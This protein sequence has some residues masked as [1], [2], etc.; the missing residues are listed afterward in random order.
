MPPR[1]LVASKD[2]VVLDGLNETADAVSLRWGNYDLTT[3]N[4]DYNVPQ[5]KIT[6]YIEF[7]KTADF[8]DVTSIQVSGNEKTFTNEELNLVLSKYGFETRVAAPV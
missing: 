1:S 3:S 2:V 4:P 6:H 7:S 8:T 5:G